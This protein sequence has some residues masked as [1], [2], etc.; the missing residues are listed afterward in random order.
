M[1]QFKILIPPIA[2]TDIKI[3]LQIIVA[4]TLSV[5]SLSQSGSYGFSGLDEFVI[6]KLA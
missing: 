1:F 5:S 6:S 3:E 2:N 4:L